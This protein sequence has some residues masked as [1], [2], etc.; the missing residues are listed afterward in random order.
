MM[1][2]SEN[3]LDELQRASGL[4]GEVPGRIFEGISLAIPGK[5]SYESY[6]DSKINFRRNIWMNYLGTLH[7]MPNFHEKKIQFLRTHCFCAS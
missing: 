6:R 3:S 7:G 1:K 5:M 4:P 2:F